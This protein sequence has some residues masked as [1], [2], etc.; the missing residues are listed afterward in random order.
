MQETIKIVVVVLMLELL[1]GCAS[2]SRQAGDLAAINMPT[3]DMQYGNALEEND[4]RR[5]GQICNTCESLNEKSL[6]Q[7]TFFM[8]DQLKNEP[9]MRLDWVKRN[10]NEYSDE[11]LGVECIKI[12]LDTD[13]N[14]SASLPVDI[15]MRLRNSEFGRKVLAAFRNNRLPR[16]LKYQSGQIN[17]FYDL[18]DGYIQALRGSDKGLSPT[19]ISR[20]QKIAQQA[21]VNDYEQYS[22]IHKI[23]PRIDQMNTQIERERCLCLWMLVVP[24]GIYVNDPKVVDALKNL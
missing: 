4:I 5:A 8:E 20:F 23:P 18:R 19:E 11:E 7:C 13:Q 2:G 1:I 9:E 17:Q 22:A 24:G 10:V 6:R 3:C 14:L 16:S 12:W 21:L 15:S